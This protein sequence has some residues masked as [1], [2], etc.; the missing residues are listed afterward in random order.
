M[1]II[2]LIRLFRGT[3]HFLI[4]G[5]FPE[6][7][8]NLCSRAGIPIWDIRPRDKGAYEAATYASSYRKLRPH[9]RAS[10]TRLKVSRRE[11]WPFL[12]GR[13]RRRWGLVLGV[14]A[15]CALL[16]YMSGCVW[17]VEVHGCETIDPAE[18]TESLSEL[19]LRPGVRSNSVDARRLENEMMLREEKLSW[20][21]VNLIGSR[22]V[23]EI[24]ERVPAPEQIDY[25]NRACNI[26]ASQSGQIKY[27][28][29]YEGQSV[30]KV[31]DTVLAGEVIVSGIT[32]DS[33]GNTRLQYA[34]AKVVAQVYEDLEVVVPL[35]ENELVET[36]EATVLHRLRVLGMSLPLSLPKK[37]TETYVESEEEQELLGQQWLGLVTVT[38]QPAAYQTKTYTEA[39]AKEEAEKRL[40]ALE[41]ERFGGAEILDRTLEGSCDGTEFTLKARYTLE[42]DIAKTVE[43]LMN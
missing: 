2:K 24:K 6:R 43:I 38:R 23:I 1:F 32:E 37:M 31:G 14:A 10:G 19:G 3:V 41:R 7:F 39:E 30:L 13:Y 15:A 36:G 20:I 26:V 16:F 27:M 25:D 22:A 33:Y 34:R 11:G 8:L 42:K 17:K 29:V 12:R 21:A 4:F 18:I 9:A 5:N 40:L 35:E 28:E